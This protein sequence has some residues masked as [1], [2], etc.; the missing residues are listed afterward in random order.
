[1][2]LGLV[3]AIIP[4]FSY[5]EVIDLAADLELK[6]V[7]MMSWPHGRA[8]RRYAGVTHIDADS[9]TEEL[10][11][12]YVEYAAERGIR[13]SALG[14][15]PNPL[16]K[17]LE[18]REK[19]IE[20]IYKLI[21]A[22]RMMDVN[23][24]STF[25]GRNT[26][27]NPEQ[28]IEEMLSVW[29]PIVQYAYDQGVKVLIENCPMYYTHDEWPN[30][31]NLACNPYIWDI[32][33]SE[34]PQPNFGLNYDPSHMYLQRADYIRPLIDYKDRIFHIHLK[35]IKFSEEGLYRYGMFWYPSKFHAPKIPS[36]G[37]IDWRAFI[38]ALYDL[39]YDIPVCLEI[40]DKAFEDSLEDI[41]SSIKISVRYI[42]N[43]ME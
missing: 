24:I 8:L 22:S 42:R 14:Y 41:L 31:A 17:D 37:G 16:D 12:R 15:Y 40:E 7:E 32:M 34:M 13:V 28:N 5:E 4:N 29:K 38:S 27:L 43:F 26:N 11:K 3:S 36:L 1:M 23:C 18:A 2:K 20:H 33:F 6:Y 10:A 9:L 25:I 39:R 21:N 19:Y 30:G 35:D